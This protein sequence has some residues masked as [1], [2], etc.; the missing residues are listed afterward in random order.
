M[1]KGDRVPCFFS[2]DCTVVDSHLVLWAVAC[3]L[4]LS[5]VL[6]LGAVEIVFC[7]GGVQKKLQ[8]SYQA[9]RPVRL[10]YYLSYR[11]GYWFRLSLG[12]YL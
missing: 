3:E 8:T 11:L 2:V 10:D 7:R 1:K 9:I 6:D 4:V 5:T 12:L